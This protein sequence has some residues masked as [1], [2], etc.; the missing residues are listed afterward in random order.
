MNQREA[1]E[2]YARA[3]AQYRRAQTIHHREQR[4]GLTNSSVQQTRRMALAVASLSR[5][6]VRLDQAWRETKW[7]K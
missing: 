4:A 5:A 2:R 1:N 3:A 7:A 6:Y